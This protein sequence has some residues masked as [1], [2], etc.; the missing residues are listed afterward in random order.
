M[1]NFI[2]SLQAENRELKANAETARE[3]IQ[4]L[5]AY[6]ASSK[7]TGEGAGELSGYV[8]VKDVE[9]RLMQILNGLDGF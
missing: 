4:A 9:S 5:R 7:F 1:A 2:Q 3:E 8:S 6:L